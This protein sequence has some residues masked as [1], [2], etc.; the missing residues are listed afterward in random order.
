MQI[1]WDVFIELVSY[2]RNLHVSLR[3]RLRLRTRS[4]KERTLSSEVRYGY[5]NDVFQPKTPPTQKKSLS[6]GTNR[7]GGQNQPSTV[8]KRVQY[9][10]IYIYLSLLIEFVVAD[11][12][13]IRPLG[14][15]AAMQVPEVMLELL[16][17]VDDLLDVALAQDD[18]PV[19]VADVVEIREGDGRLE[20]CG[21]QM[22]GLE[23]QPMQALSLLSYLFF[24]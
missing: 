8:P 10:Y 16:G 2:I 4:K 21:F 14:L 9:I 15:V 24:R 1:Q 23:S 22:G 7:G 20:G 6:G 13:A 19:L 11:P 12:L 3:L 17:H 5:Q 18:L